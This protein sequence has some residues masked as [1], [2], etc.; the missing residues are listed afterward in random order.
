MAGERKMPSLQGS[1]PE[2]NLETDNRVFPTR[3]ILVS[4]LS[5][6]LGV[7]GGDVDLGLNR[8]AEVEN[9]RFLRQCTGYRNRDSR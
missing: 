3:C 5:H 7:A 6:L 2:R 8:S 9:K 4:S 1:T